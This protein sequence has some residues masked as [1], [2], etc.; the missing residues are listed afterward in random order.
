LKAK[1][2]TMLFE[3]RKQARFPAWLI[4]PEI[5]RE[6]RSRVAIGVRPGILN[7]IAL[8]SLPM[9]MPVC[10]VGEQDTLFGGSGTSIDSPVSVR[11]PDSLNL[12][13]RTSLSPA[14]VMRTEPSLHTSTEL[15]PDPVLKV[16]I[17]SS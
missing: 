5:T 2:L 3:V 10:A 1:L 15:Q 9:T 7:E 11:A 17:A 13:R 8:P 6:P 16:P 4:A 12:S 14:D